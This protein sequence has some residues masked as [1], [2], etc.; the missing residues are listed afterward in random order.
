M[1]K[2]H[3]SSYFRVMEKCIELILKKHNTRVNLAFYCQNT[4]TPKNLPN[5]TCVT[6]MKPRDTNS[7]E[8]SSSYSGSPV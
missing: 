4:G 3:V 1:T 7:L 5:T 6:R 8:Q 2:Q